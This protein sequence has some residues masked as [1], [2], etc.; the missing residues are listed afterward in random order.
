MYFIAPYFERISCIASSVPHL[1]FDKHPRLPN[2]NCLKR[3]K[4]L[5]DAVSISLGI[6][7]H[8]ELT[9][10]ISPPQLHIGRSITSGG[11]DGPHMARSHNRIASNTCMLS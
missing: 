6:L 1:A 4:R 2:L 11:V 5:K 10:V 9:P 3:S 7:V 8:G